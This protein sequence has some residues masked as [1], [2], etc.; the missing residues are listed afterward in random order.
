MIKA[1]FSEAQL[2]TLRESFKR[3]QSFPVDKLPDMRRLLDTMSDDAIKQVMKADIR[4]LSPLAV[5]E[6]VRRDLLK[7][8]R[9]S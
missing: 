5:N 8:G 9:V 7:N 2:S 1:A 4:W 3:I 6:A